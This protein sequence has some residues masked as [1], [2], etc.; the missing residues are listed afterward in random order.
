MCP[1]F[2]SITRH[3]VWA[4]LIIILSLLINELVLA[5]LFYHFSLFVDFLNRHL[6]GRYIKLVGLSAVCVHYCSPSGDVLGPDCSLFRVSLVCNVMNE[7]QL[8]HLFFPP[9]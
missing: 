9:A 7:A 3:T 6:Q 5:I 1:L 4:F 2:I 8:P